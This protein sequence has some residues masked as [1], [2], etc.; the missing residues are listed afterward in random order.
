MVGTRVSVNSFIQM[1]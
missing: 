1:E